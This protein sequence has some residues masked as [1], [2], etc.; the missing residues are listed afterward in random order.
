[1]V[2]HFFLLI[3]I[4][5]SALP[6]NSQDIPSQPFFGFENHSGKPE[7]FLPNIVS[8]MS[9][10]TN[11]TFSPDGTLFL[12]ST[13]F[14]SAGSTIIYMQLTDGKWS[15]PE[16]ASFSG[17]Y[18]DID[19]IFST[20]GKRIY[21][22]SRR[23]M[24]EGRD[25]SDDTNLWFV[26]HN[27]GVF[28]EPEE[29]SDVI[30][31]GANQ[32]YNSISG[33]GTILFH[34]KNEANNSMDIFKATERN[35]RYTVE[36]LGVEINTADNETDPYI[37]PEE[38]YLIFSSNRAGGYGGVDLY[39]SFATEQ[40]WGQPINLGEEINSNS[41]DY[42]PC[43]TS[44]GLIMTFTS[45][46]MLDFWKPEHKKDYKTLMKK[47]NGPDNQLDNIWWVNAQFL[48]GLKK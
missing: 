18:P 9:M 20:D 32:Y 15:E 12:Y 31:N 28:G 45:N 37:S 16:I 19:P 5:F 42:A 24:N 34:A 29:L 35:G 25:K 30:N 8:T 14:L 40:G 6:C 46:R 1:M 3:I 48:H 44:N 33:R 2:K 36:S 47:I 21:F 10:E 13:Q 7:I 26:E 27:N 43:I 23:P 39:I 22:T 4:L 41:N 38:D 11:G 17:K